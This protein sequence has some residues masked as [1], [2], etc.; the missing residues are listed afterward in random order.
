MLGLCLGSR[1]AAPDSRFREDDFHQEPGG[2]TR[3][4]RIVL[5]FGRGPN[6]EGKG[7]GH[8]RVEFSG[9]PADGSIRRRFIDHDGEPLDPQPDLEDLAHLQRSHP[10]LL[11]RFA[12][13]QYGVAP[14]SQGESAGRGQRGRGNLESTVARVYHDLT[15]SRAPLPADEIADGLAAAHRLLGGGEAESGSETPVRRIVDE[16]LSE[17]RSLA[18]ENTGAT[19][20]RSGRGGQ[21]L[22]LLLV[23]GAMLDL[24]RDTT[25]PAG[26]RPII[27]IEEPEA[28][29]HPILLAST[30]DAIERLQAQTVITTNSGELLSS[31]PMT[32]LRRLVRAEREIGVYRLR[33]RSLSESD[34]RRVRYHIRARRGGVLFARCW[35]LVEG[36]S[37]FWLLSQ[38]ARVLGYD[39]EAEGV[40]PIE[41]AQCGVA[42]LVKLARDMGIEW[43]LLADG[44]EA[45]EGYARDAAEHLKGAEKSRRITRLGRRDIEHCLWH[46]GFD[47]VYRKAA[48]SS[49][50]KDRQGREEPPGRLISKAVRKTSKPYLALAVAEAAADRGPESVPPELR[51]VIETSVSLARQIERTGTA[52][53][54]GSTGGH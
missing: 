38:L 13:P 10:F 25:V 16:L 44:D 42:P 53:A 35:L 18:K 52:T 11:L 7:Q 23:L 12:H 19:V 30:W 32:S 28:H 29:L 37:E 8:T 34:M 15:H 40:R 14:V 51:K 6:A 36:E 4:I 2:R 43:H 5:T 31:V 39:L 3:A 24:H 22:G 33:S 27:A 1:G 45:G 26:A 9:D 49:R 20:S 21:S 50:G 48:R 47:D 41:F 17:V 54:L 46:H